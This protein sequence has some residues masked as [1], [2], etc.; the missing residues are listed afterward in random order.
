MYLKA[1]AGY[2]KVV[3]PEH[4]ECQNLQEIL[5]DL[6]TITEEKAIKGREEPVTDLQGNVSRLDSKRAL[7]TS[8]QHRL[9]RKLRLR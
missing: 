8:R 9:F 7:S 3:G 4:P 5:Q 6:E 1:L 2:E